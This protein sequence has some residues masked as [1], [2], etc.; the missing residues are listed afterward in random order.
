MI[1]LYIL[2]TFVV[3]V[4]IVICIVFLHGGPKKIVLYRTFRQELQ[5]NS[6]STI[7]PIP[8]NIKPPAQPQ[9]GIPKLI[10]RTWED[11]S[12][13]TKYR[14]AFDHTQ[15]LLPDWSQKVY[16]SKDQEKFIYT[17]YKAYPEII[18]AYNLCNYGVMK[19]DFWRYLAIYHYGGLYL[20]MKSSVIK[21]FNFDLD[22]TKAYISPWEIR[23]HTYIFPPQGE[24]QNWWI[25]APPKSSLLW[26]LI[27]QIVANI[28]YLYQHKTAKFLQLVRVIPHSITKEHI[29]ATTGP[30]VYSYVIKQNPHDVLGLDYDGNLNLEYMFSQHE[31]TQ[32][33]S[34]H[35][36]NQTKP[37]LT[38]YKIF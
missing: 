7:Y 6:P 2:T 25:M 31:Y 33:S 12:W 30:I 35:Y 9:K 23:N 37:L 4:I 22:V 38:H 13:K 26:K 20:D 15:K 34:Q 18:Q 32:V 14:K 21:P 10:F 24:Y 5:N 3:I 36:S 16:T 19:A 28:L 1:W 17:I 27:W 8:K 11:E 29:L